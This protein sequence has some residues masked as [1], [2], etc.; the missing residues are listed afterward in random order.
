MPMALEKL[1]T[2][3]ELS[4]YLRVNRFTV[5]RMATKGKLPGIKVADM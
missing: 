2:I 4:A 5:Y 1:L 3:E